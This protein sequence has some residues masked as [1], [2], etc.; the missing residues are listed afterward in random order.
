MEKEAQERSVSGERPVGP[1]RDTISVHPG[2]SRDLF[3]WAVPRQEGI[4]QCLEGQWQEYLKTVPYPTS[5]WGTSQSP[6]LTLWDD[7]AILDHVVGACQWPREGVSR[8]LPILR[9]EAQQVLSN[10]DA[11]DKG[12]HRRIKTTAGSS[13]SS[14]AETQRQRFR[15]F[16][17][18]EAE[19]PREV[20]SQLWELCHRWLEPES[21]TKEQILE[22]LVLEQFLTVLP[23]GIQSQ[24]LECGPK[25]CAQAVALAEGFLL[26]QQE[27]LQREPQESDSFQEAA[28]N[29]SEGQRAV[30]DAR[31]R[32]L[33]KEVRKHDNGKASLLG[34]KVTNRGAGAIQNQEVRDEG[35]DGA[36]SGTLK[37]EKPYICMD[38]GKCFVRPSDL[39]KHDNIHTSAK[40]FHCME[41][42][43]RFTQ[44]PHLTR[45]QRI[46]TGEK[47]HTCTDCGASF[48]QR[49]SLVSH[50]RV[51]SAEQ[52]YHC[53][54]CPQCFSH[55]S[56]LKVHERIHTGQKP[57]ICLECGKRFVSSSTLKIHKRIHTGEKPFSCADCGKRFI[58]RSN[59]ISHQRTHSGEKPF[60]CTVCGRRFSYPSDLTRH[61]KIHTGEKPFPCDECERRFTRFSDLLIHWRIH[62]GERPYRCLECGRR[63]RQ[64]SALVTHQ[65]IH[66]K[67]KAAENIKPV[68]STQSQENNELKI[69]ETEEKVCIPEE[70]Q[71]NDASET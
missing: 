63:F 33:A 26:S 43:T 55:Q 10:L 58:Q 45:H 5:G 3:Q 70:T 52:P 29:L 14:T 36:F 34:S 44:L 60:C 30:S 57:Y 62:T 47:P 35:T 17:Y 37:K 38:C 4:S 16:R 56:A 18:Q 19:G 59:L 1:G 49:V 25:T 48:A 6:D 28:M 40:H 20:C 24:V 69:S 39:A 11:R 66:M 2:G 12:D 7:L 27:N 21:H 68:V 71:E 53:S 13:H 46:H 64:K 32:L 51:H 23:K 8:L 15:H 9:A 61:Q 50:Q 54:H 42:G 41:C 31:Q 22:L 65:R 67:E